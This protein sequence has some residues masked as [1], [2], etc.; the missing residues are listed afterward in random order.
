MTEQAIDQRAAFEG[1][2]RQKAA[3][4]P[5]FRAELSDNPAEALK[6]AFGL[7]IPA[8]FTLRVVNE[9]PG[10]LVLVLPS[11][12]RELNDDELDSVSGGGFFDLLDRLRP[13]TGSPIAGIIAG[14]L[15]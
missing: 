14:K 5:A 11:P 6:S 7:D 4:D 13:V 1:A 3:T 12:T 10:E 15:L 9:Q 2:I 8:S